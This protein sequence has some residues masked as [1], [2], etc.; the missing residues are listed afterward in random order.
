MPVTVTRFI[1][2]KITPHPAPCIEPGRHPDAVDLG[3]EPYGYGS[4]ALHMFCPNCGLHFW[5]PYRE[6]YAVDH[7]VSAKQ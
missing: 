4:M 1:C 7:D 5:L 3:I 2:T 6:D